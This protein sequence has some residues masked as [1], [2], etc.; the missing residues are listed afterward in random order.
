MPG[1]PPNGMFEQM[2]TLVDGIYI[3]HIGGR[4]VALPPVKDSFRPDSECTLYSIRKFS[5]SYILAAKT[6]QLNP[7]ALFPIIE[8]AFKRP[9]L[10][11]PPSPLLFSP[12]SLPTGRDLPIGLFFDLCYLEQ[13]LAAAGIEIALPFDVFPEEGNSNNGGGGGNGANNNGNT[14]SSSSSLPRPPLMPGTSSL[15]PL[16]FA[17]DPTFDRRAFQ[18][19]TQMGDIEG[20]FSFLNPNRDFRFLDL[21][22]TTDIPS[23]E[24]PSHS[25]LRRYIYLSF[26]PSPF[27]S[28]ILESLHREALTAFAEAEKASLSGIISSLTTSSSSSSSTNEK[29]GGNKGS[30]GAGGQ[31]ETYMPDILWGCLHLRVESDFKN[32]IGPGYK[33]AEQVSITYIQYIPYI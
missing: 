33:S 10:P 22:H 32:F 3:S 27:L 18:K 21:G 19:A 16:N 26:I 5:I 11:T 25:L 4:R 17:Y 12:P 2:A 14:S 7:R 28:H 1:V 31:Q 23:F 24:S 29:D 9:A 15:D 30:Q 13:R 6:H 8:K 20:A